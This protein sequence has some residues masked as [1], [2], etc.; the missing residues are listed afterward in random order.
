MFSNRL[1]LGIILECVSV[2]SV[3]ITRVLNFI[4][5]FKLF[6]LK[7]IVIHFHSNIDHWSYSINYLHWGE[8]KC[9]Y[10]CPGSSAEKFEEAMK[11]VAPELFKSQPDLLHQLVTI[12][13]PNVLESLGVPICT[14]NQHAGEFISKI[15][16]HY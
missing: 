16:H 3:G 12:C 10:G 15:F 13:N 9:W 5:E 6:V 11:S 4:S 14:T 7:L 8:Q 1:Y 2:L